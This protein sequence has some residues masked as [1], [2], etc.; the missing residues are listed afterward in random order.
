LRK[1]VSISL[2]VAIFVDPPAG[3]EALR[4]CV[5]ITA[6]VVRALPA[7]ANPRSGDLDTAIGQE[8]AR[9]EQSFD[10]RGRGDDDVERLAGPKPQGRSTFATWVLSIARNMALATLRRQHHA[11]FDEA[12]LE[13]IEDA[14]DDPETAV[15]KIDRSRLLRQILAD[16]PV[17]HR[18][19]IDLVYYHEKSLPEVATILRVRL[20]T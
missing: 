20:K 10:H 8:K 14:A 2:A 12:D 19:I 17:K 9:R 1:R 13:T 15:Q 11:P 3:R 6:R 4:R 7:D 16:L 5:L 18:E